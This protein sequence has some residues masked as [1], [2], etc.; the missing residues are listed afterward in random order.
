MN[1]NQILDKVRFDTFKHRQGMME[2]QQ[3]K[4]QGLGLEREERPSLTEAMVESESAA[5]R[6]AGAA[7]VRVSGAVENVKQLIDRK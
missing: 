2:S 5:I 7:C 1:H 4:G 6:A 3:P